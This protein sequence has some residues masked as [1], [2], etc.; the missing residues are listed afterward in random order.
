MESLREQELGRALSAL[1]GTLGVA[2]NGDKR[3]VAIPSVEMFWRAY[4]DALRVLQEPI[5]TPYEGDGPSLRV[6]KE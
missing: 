1:L 5:G 6:V 2:T 4:D 3:T